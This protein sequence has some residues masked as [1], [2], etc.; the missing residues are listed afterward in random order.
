MENLQEHIYNK[1]VDSNGWSLVEIMTVLVIIFV[2]GAFAAPD[3]LQWRESTRVTSA[4]RD[5][6]ADLN[7]AKITAIETNAPVVANITTGDS[8]AYTIFVDDGSDSGV[9]GNKTQDGTEET[10]KSR[11][12]T[13]DEYEGTSIVSISLT[14]PLLTFSP[15]GIVEDNKAREILISNTDRDIWLKILVASGGALT[16]LK[17]VDSTNGS[18]GTWN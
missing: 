12:F 18:N 15:R 10:V 7:E 2:L 13:D 9:S 4:A 14:S 6:V 17:S 16:L 5:F 3:I 8:S 1:A 11:D